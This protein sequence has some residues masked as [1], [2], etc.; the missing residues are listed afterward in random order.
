MN[1]SLSRLDARDVDLEEL[2]QVIREKGRPVRVGA[3]ARTAVRS[4]LEIKSGQRSYAPGAKYLKG[5]TIQLRGQSAKIESVLA[6]GNPAQGR[7][8][9]LRLMLADG[10]EVHVPAEV[11]GAPAQDRRP[12]MGDQIDRVIR[13]HGLAC[14]AA[15]HEA[16]NGDGRFVRF[17]D[18]QGDCW[19][20]AEMLPEVGDEDLA[21][22]AD[23]LVRELDSGEPVSKT[24]EELVRAT[25]GSGDDG[26][27][28]YA[29]RAFTLGRAL[30]T[31]VDVEHLGGQWVWAET[32]EAFTQREP[33]TVPRI[34]TQGETAVDTSVV[35]EAGAEEESQVEQG[36]AHELRPEREKVESEDLEA[37]RKSRPRQAVFTLSARH[38]YEGWFP[39]TKQVE[40]LFPPLEHGKQEV[41][42]HYNF[43]NESGCFKAW[44]DRVERRIWVSRDMYETFR[45]HAVY[46]GAR[47]RLS[48]RT[49]RGY[50]IA[51]RP[52]TKTEPVRV[53]RVQLLE[54]GAIAHSEDLEARRYDIDDD[55]FVADV[56]FEDREALFQQAMKVGNSIFGIMRDQARA[57]WEAQGQEDLYVTAE[58]LFEAIHFDEQGRMISKATIAWELWRRMAFKPV[59]RG[60]YLFRPQ[61]GALLRRADAH[62]GVK[63]TKM[64]EV[65]TEVGKTRLRGDIVR[66]TERKGQIYEALD[67]GRVPIRRKAS[68]T[69]QPELPDMGRRILIR[70]VP[71]AGGRTSQVHFTREI[72]ETYFHFVLGRPRTIRLQR[73][74]PGSAPGPIERRPLVYSES[75]RNCRIEVS[76]AR[77]L[78]ELYPASGQRPIIVFEEVEA[79][80]FRYMLLLPG[81]DGFAQLASHLDA[82]PR[83]KALAFDITDLG[84][85]QEIWP[86]YPASASGSNR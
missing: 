37:W 47:L 59:G 44:V 13:Q 57:W 51:T 24:T 23:G 85:L 28:T 32:W 19:C 66:K 65:A 29:L 81:D 52:T 40:R 76:G 46:P 6:G 12:V 20:L 84:T 78:G 39:L 79:D 16:M 74:Q 58:D 7:F 34:S 11:N 1:T 21:K 43:G 71:R 18:A 49:E 33:L 15:V 14:R 53:W 67:A 75:N 63:R 80:L 82:L 36:E 31:C 86:D 61:F 22:V 27:N 68:D 25:W 48:Y 56:R 3:L 2:A 45:Y 26:S 64:M 10:T 42:F 69:S 70:F 83:G 17:Q 35:S 55:V 72:A 30:S 73:L 60:R 8:S 50:D 77:Q 38:Y 9:V 54:D 4:Q 41:I 62:V 5:Q